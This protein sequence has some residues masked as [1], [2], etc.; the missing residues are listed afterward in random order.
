VGVI[1]RYDHPLTAGLS[2]RM[3]Y[4]DSLVY[5]PL[6]VPEETADAKRLGGIQWPAAEDGPGLLVRE[7][8]RGA[9]GN[10]QPGPRGEGDYAVVF[11]AA[12]PLPAELLRM[13]AMYSGTH[14]YGD[15]DDDIVFADTGTFGVHAVRPG[16]RTFKLPHPS[17]VWDLIENKLVPERTYQITLTGEP[18]QTFFFRLEPASAQ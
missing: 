3:D 16:T 15:S 2:K 9:S 13:L 18:P 11:T 4:G 14:V 8:G 5:G 10:G 6:L 12:V 17:R 7:F 1:D